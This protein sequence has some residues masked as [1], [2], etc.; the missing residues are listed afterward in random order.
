M[1]KVLATSLSMLFL[2]SGSALAGDATAGK[3]KAQ[4]CAACHGDGSKTLMPYFP[5]LSGQNEDYLIKV[6][7][8]YKSGARNNPI[9]GPQAVGLSETDIENLAAYFSSQPGLVVKK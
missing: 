7:K 6:L 8:D 3:E 9:M 1:N 4:A 2:V 5:R